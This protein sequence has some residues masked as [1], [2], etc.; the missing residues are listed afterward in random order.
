[1][2]NNYFFVFMM[3]VLLGC[4]KEDVVRE[5][6]QVSTYD[7]SDISAEG[8]VFHAEL[9]SNGSGPV[10]AYGFV[11]DRHKLP[12]LNTFADGIQ[13]TGPISPGV[14]SIE[15]HRSLNKEE[16]YYVRAFA[17]TEQYTTYGNQVEFISQGSEK[18]V[19]N[20]IV[21]KRG[22]PG[23]TVVIK[24]RNFSKNKYNLIVRFNANAGLIIYATDTMIKVVAQVFTEID[25]EV[26]VSM[27]GNEQ[28]AKDHF[29]FSAPQI[30][31]FNPKMGVAGDVVTIDGQNFGS[32]N[33]G[34]KV[35]FGDYSAVF[36][37]STR[38]RIEVI[39]PDLDTL[40]DNPTGP[41]SQYL[42]K[43]IKVEVADF[44]VVATSDF[45]YVLPTVTD[46][47]PKQVSPGDHVTIKGANFDMFGDRIEVWLTDDQ[48]E[49]ISIS[50]TEIIFKTPMTPLFV[51]EIIRVQ[52]PSFRHEFASRLLYK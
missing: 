50:P 34:Y 6:P 13:K 3:M 27:F 8:A 49:I 30:T 17:R 22:I 44:S 25:N 42:N 21:P 51:D 48:A 1:M 32:P 28:V 4:Q 35:R 15:V 33:Y 23:D 36:L 9:L 46:F 52:A 11:W 12:K 19:V 29:I 5:F 41:L 47:S 45:N 31:D 26:K 20:D 16:K 24:G 37:N 39:V 43:S 14:F 18:P 2:R 40:F 7:I 38:N 10:L